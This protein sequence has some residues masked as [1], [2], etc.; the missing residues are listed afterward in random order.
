[1]VG[2]FGCT[3]SNIE[4]TPLAVPTPR[5]LACI[6][7]TDATRS[8]QFIRPDTA[9][10]R[11]L[12]AHYLFQGVELS[13]LAVLPNSYKQTVYYSGKLHLD[14][15]PASSNF[16]VNR[17]NRTENQRRI[18]GL[19]KILHP[20]LDST[21]KQFIEMAVCD[22]SD[23]NGALYKAVITASNPAYK[24]RNVLVII[25]SDLLQDLI[26]YVEEETRPM[27]F[28]SNTRLVLIGNH[29]TID[30]K[31]LF[32]RHS[33]IELPSFQHLQTLTKLELWDTQ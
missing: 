29:P 18:S 15:L 12:L 2:S 22:S 31:K 27:Q 26:K 17:K 1:M 11:I 30:L 33:P 16:I 24:D 28:P 8:D 14:T 3:P 9:T 5:P 21:Q 6:L 32:P 19:G 25:A 13:V 4:N 23:V 10:L 20:V 7:V